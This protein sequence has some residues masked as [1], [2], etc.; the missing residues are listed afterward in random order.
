MYLI[1]AIP[2]ESYTKFE[3]EIANAGKEY[4]DDNYFHKVVLSDSYITLDELNEK[5]YIK[6]K[7]V[8]G[9]K[10]YVYYNGENKAYIKCKTYKTMNY[11]ASYEVIT[12]VNVEDIK[13]DDDSTDTE[14]VN[15]ENAKEKFNNTYNDY[16]YFNNR[17]YAYNQNSYGIFY[18]IQNTINEVNPGYNIITSLNNYH[19]TYNNNYVQVINTDVQDTIAEIYYEMP[20]NTEFDNIIFL[21]KNIEVD[22]MDFNGNYL[23]LRKQDLSKCDIYKLTENDELLL[24]YQDSEYCGF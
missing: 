19:I 6:N 22:N 15:I 18:T 13:S 8:N 20:N 9:C 1:L 7:L 4:L 5:G 3:N 10:G 23:F 24:Q 11:N 14:L 21:E 16:Y 2:R 17:V 12:K